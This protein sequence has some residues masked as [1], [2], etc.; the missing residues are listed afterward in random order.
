MSKVL[1]MCNIKFNNLMFENDDFFQ[2]FGIGLNLL[3]DKLKIFKF[4][5]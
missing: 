2:K 3:F 4:R 5:F 1:G